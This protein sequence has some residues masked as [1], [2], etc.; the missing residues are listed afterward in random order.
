MLRGR[1]GREK[2]GSVDWGGSSGQ[3]VPWEHRREVAGACRAWHEVPGES[4]KA[5]HPIP[6]PRLSYCLRMVIR[7]GPEDEG[8][9]YK[10]HSHGTLGIEE[11]P[12]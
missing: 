4:Q 1:R 5:S 9:S 11:S 6:G 2:E 7:A 8:G 10:P 12:V 3:R